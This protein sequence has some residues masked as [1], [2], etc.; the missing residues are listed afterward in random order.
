MSDV[1]FNERFK[2]WM[3][4]EIKPS[5]DSDDK[6]LQSVSEEV[7]IDD[8]REDVTDIRE[9]PESFGNQDEMVGL[10]Q[11]GE[12]EAVVE[13]NGSSDT[14]GMVEPWENDSLLEE[15]GTDGE[16]SDNFE[17]RL[18]D[19]TE[20]A[21]VVDEAESVDES[22][23]YVSDIRSEIEEQGGDSSL[24]RISLDMFGMSEIGSS[25]DDE[26]E[27]GNEGVMESRRGINSI[28]KKSFREL[29]DGKKIPRFKK[30][31]VLTAII[32]VALLFLIFVNVLISG[33]GGGNSYD[34]WLA[35]GGGNDGPRDNSDFV[36]R[37]LARQNQERQT[38]QQIRQ[39]T[40]PDEEL[41]VD[42]F[43]IQSPPVFDEPFRRPQ[44]TTTTVSAPQPSGG[45]V[46]Q[47][48]GTMRIAGFSESDMAAIGSNIRR[49]GGFGAVAVSM[50]MPDTMMGT[51]GQ[52]GMMNN[53]FGGGQMMSRDEYMS[54]QLSALGQ[55]VN[56]PGGQMGAGG[57]GASSAFSGNERA[58]SNVGRF[59][60][61]G[62]YNA[63]N[64]D[65]GNLRYIG[66]NAL[67]PGTIIHAVLVSR[68]DTDYPGPIHARVTQNVYDS[69]TGLHLLIP[70]GTILQGNYSSS[71]IGVA[72]VQIA[73]ES[74]VVNY[75]GVA[76]Q[77]SLGGMAGVDRRGRA[78]ISGT[79][80]DNYFEWLKAAGI[81]SLF[82]LIN[83]EIEYQSG[84][85][86]SALQ[87]EMMQSNAN[88][89]N[90]LGGRIMERALDIQ[91]TV[92]VRNGKPVSVSVNT[93]LELRS[94]PAIAA[95]QR[96]VR[97]SRSR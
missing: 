31:L 48:S 17:S 21:S 15:K 2:E 45:A 19:D 32:A 96:Y 91:P 18:I 14:M 26:D 67:F 10:A 84:G 44:A 81:I 97:T 66:D 9:I 57:F 72:K 56:S 78:G 80:D 69:M 82:T 43:Y 52:T 64:Q 34:E 89:F 94:F 6:E 16:E 4:S 75:Q 83:S 5:S 86:M 59:S 30:S 23:V 22:N 24:D 90:Q 93:V 71:S 73:W 79:L 11:R 58:N 28:E 74:M 25:E 53:Q 49:D 85:Q 38:Q 70:Q 95:E 7:G 27:M 60:D 87:R 62:A 42:E 41:E 61:S 39:R 77:V 46:S 68:I 29:R 65:A 88:L 55:L 20:S 40:F 33:A 47:G 92:R 12:D 54:Q 13:S 51:M 3:N 37:D 8:N 50:T 63:Q 76:Y 35:S 1:D 36:V